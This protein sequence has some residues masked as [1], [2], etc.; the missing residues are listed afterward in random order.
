[1]KNTALTTINASLSDT[2]WVN[3]TVIS[4]LPA[5]VASFTVFKCRKIGN[6]AYVQGRVDANTL[7]LNSSVVIGNVPS[8]MFPTTP[9]NNTMAPITC[10]T[11]S[12]VAQINEM[13]VDFQGNL[14]LRRYI[15][16]TTSSVIFFGSY[17]TN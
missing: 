9:N 15:T 10:Y 17:L 3:G 12:N 8:T 2:G 4:P 1:M 16:V 6:I 5:G 11:G 7:V 14:T 13:C